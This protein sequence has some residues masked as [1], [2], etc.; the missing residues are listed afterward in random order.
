MKQTSCVMQIPNVFNASASV[1]FIEIV[2]MVPSLSL[3]LA[4]IRVYV[5]LE[6]ELSC[7]V[8]AEMFKLP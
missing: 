6:V 4:P 8:L 2:K 5:T 1:L 3:L 7:N